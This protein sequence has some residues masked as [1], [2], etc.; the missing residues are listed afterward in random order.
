MVI[1]LPMVFSRPGVSGNPL[2]RPRGKN[3]LA[4]KRAARSYSER[5]IHR[6]AEI[7]ED[8]DLRAGVVAA[9]AI[10]DRAVGLPKQE[11]TVTAVTTQEQGLAREILARLLTTPAGLQALQTIQAALPQTINVTPKEPDAPA[12]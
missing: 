12:E 6:L 3:A 2:G 5:A 7:M 4:V 8:D 10:L 9:K 1:V 11:L